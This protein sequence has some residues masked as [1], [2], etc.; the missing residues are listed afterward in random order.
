MR[1]ESVAKSDSSLTKKLIFKL[2]D[3]FESVAKSDSSLTDKVT[4]LLGG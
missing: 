3:G 4:A 2:V 1:F